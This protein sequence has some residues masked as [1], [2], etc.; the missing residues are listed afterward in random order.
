[1]RV[2]ACSLLAFV[3]VGFTV[4]PALTQDKM[5]AVSRAKA[6]FQGMPV[7]PKCASISPANGDPSKG[8]AVIM[9]KAAA[10]CVIPWHWHSAGEQLMFVAG[11]ANVQMKEGAPA[12]LNGGDY[13]NLPSKN[14]HQ[15]TCI[16]ACSFFIA[17]DGPFDI[18]FV[19]PSG[20]EI[21]PD[22]A[23]KSKAKAPAKKPVAKGEMK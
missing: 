23:L 9:A 17:T 15:F 3:M 18:H 4:T 7:L 2:V 21:S 13:I 19:D 6:K 22:E 20:K 16:A 1:M 12:H 5:A 10:G 14:V 8:A 11:S